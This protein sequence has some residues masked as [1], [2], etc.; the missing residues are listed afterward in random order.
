M[1][2]YPKQILTISQQLQTYIDAG[3]TVSSVD[4]AAA[5][6]TTIGYYRLR[7]YSFPLYD[8]ASKRYLV[9]TDFSNILKLYHFDME[10]SRLLFGMVTCIEVALRA[11]L[12][13]ALLTYHDALILTDPSV[14]CDK[15]LFWQNLSP[16]SSQ[17][18]RSND[19]FIR[20]NFQNHD[21]EIPL[22]AAVEVMSFGTLSKT[23]K[24]LKTGKN[25][26]Y[27]I[28]AGYYRYISPRGKLV[29]P[30]LR[31]LSSWIQSVSVLRNMCA[32]NSRIYNRTINTFPELLMVDR[33][34]P[35]PLHNGLYQIL[36]AMKYL[37][38]TDK[39]WENFYTDLR[40][41]LKKYN[42]SFDFNCMNFPADWSEH[43][44]LH[45]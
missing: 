3:M 14:F 34:T 10:L 31:M 43:L 7:G 12:S 29:K 17:I 11:R 19:V 9:G 13:D 26:A 41:L 28:L 36:L 30:S 15:K 44:N 38:P 42:G 40:N 33:T 39:I 25:S 45:T 35:A 24:N 6:L 4:E 18:A 32:H 16:L 5:A 2:S 20:H 8:N 21:G 37:R 1:N 22:W 23:I 27:T